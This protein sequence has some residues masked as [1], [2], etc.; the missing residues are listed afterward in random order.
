[1]NSTQILFTIKDVRS[2]LG[3][4]PSDMLPPSVTQ[5]GTVIIK[6]DPHTEK[7]SHWLAVHYL[8]KSSSAFFFD[9]YGIE[10]LFLDIAAFIRRNST[11]SDY[12]GR[13]LKGL[14][15]NIY[16]KYCCLFALYMDRGS[17]PNNSSGNSTVRLQKQTDRSSEP[18]FPNS[19]RRRG[20][21]TAAEVAESGAPAF[22]KG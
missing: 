22:Y 14:T 1:M 15:S 5:S 20:E 3:V 17:P 8:P 11:V 21:V 12:D 4:F 16:G 18:S 2:F 6:S 19:G 13:Q 9:S 10:Q 7:G